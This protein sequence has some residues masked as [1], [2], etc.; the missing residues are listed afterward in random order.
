MR[1]NVENNICDQQG[2][3]ADSFRLPQQIAYDKMDEVNPLVWRPV[4]SD[5]FVLAAW[6]RFILWLPSVGSFGAVNNVTALPGFSRRNFI[7]CFSLTFIRDL[8]LR[9]F[10]HEWYL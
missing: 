5:V 3:R 10:R 2:P 6:E 7:G 1:A 9:R 4:L 8:S